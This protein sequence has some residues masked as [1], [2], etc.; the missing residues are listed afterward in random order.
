MANNLLIC[1]LTQSWSPTGGGG[2][3]TYLKEKK[4]YFQEHTEHRL[5]QIVPG[6]EDRITVE[7]RTIFAEVAAPLVWGSPNYRWINRND[8]V[9]AL[10]RQYQPDIIESLC[11]WVLGSRSGTV[12]AIRTPRWWQGIAP[13]FRLRRSTAS[14]GSG[15]VTR[16]GPGSGNWP[17]PMPR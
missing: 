11:P 5:L 17:M 7:G 10:L 4:K 14:G 9:F 6:P 13:I 3:S 1:D 2:I 12:G 16:W 15:L 8:A